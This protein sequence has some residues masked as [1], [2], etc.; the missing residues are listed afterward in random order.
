MNG[1][2]AYFGEQT[3]QTLQ[4]YLQNRTVGDITLALTWKE[5][6]TAGRLAYDKLL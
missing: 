4:L 1:I 5:E 3:M 2:Q 6:C